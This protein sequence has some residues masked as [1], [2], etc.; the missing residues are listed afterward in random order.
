[1]RTPLEREAVIEI[2]PLGG[3]RN[4]GWLQEGRL[5]RGEQP[6][7]D[8]DTLETLAAAGIQTVFSLRADAER[9]GPLDGRL[10]PQYAAHLQAAACDRAGLRFHHVGCT[11]FLAPAPEEVATVLRALDAEID[12]ERS[13]LVHCRA[14][15]GRTSIMT[16]TWLMSRGM[17]G[18]DVAAIHIQFLLELDD[19]LK[20][21]PDEMDAYL[22]RVRRAEQWWGFHQIAE[23]LGTQITE[24]FSMAP[25]ERPND[26]DG[27]EQRYR[28]AL[29]PWREALGR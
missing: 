3:I 13:V 24:S 11:D 21:P 12:D 27:W 14:G 2:G 20:V 18:D 1:M 26:A 22:K 28:D 4:F 25:P 6:P 8:D 9:A 5:A 16:C 29:K 17:S 23:A 15:V 10:V 7:L 19:R